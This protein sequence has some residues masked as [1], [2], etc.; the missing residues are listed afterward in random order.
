MNCLGVYCLQATGTQGG[1]VLSFEESRSQFALW[2]AMKAPL[3]LGASYSILANMSTEQPEYFELLTHPEIIAIDQDLSPAATLVLSMPSLAQQTAGAEPLTLT[4]QQCVASRGDQKWVPSPG[5]AIRGK[6]GNLCVTA[7]NGTGAMAIPCDGSPAQTWSTAQDS[8]FHVL[9]AGIGGS[10]MCLDG[11]SNAVV[12]ENVTT[13]TCA[14]NGTL[15]PPFDENSVAPQLW[16]WD[17]F[18][19]ILHGATGLCLT[20]GLSNT[21]VGNSQYVTNNGTLE[22]EVWSGHLSTPGETLA[23]LFN[24]GLTN[25]TITIGWDVIGLPANSSQPIRDVWARAALPPALNLSA[26]VQSHGVRIFVI[27]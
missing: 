4:L 3:I 14:Y 18:G 13:S 9:H 23:I 7:G 21:I 11:G 5:S 19:S 24:K 6:Y 1:T 16:V 22:H 8:A 26:L 25:E 12:P 15:P 27:G 10:G 2:A 17:R 20:L